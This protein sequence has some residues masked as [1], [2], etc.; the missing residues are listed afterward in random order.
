[1]GVTAEIRSAEPHERAALD[2]LHRRSSFVWADDRAD[3]EA[4]PDALGV[5]PEAIAEQRVRVAGEAAATRFGPA[6]RMRR[7]L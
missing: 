7:G 2:D 4:H 1:M 5:A 3:L 6:V